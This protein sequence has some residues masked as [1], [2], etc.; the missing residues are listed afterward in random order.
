MKTQISVLVKNEALLSRA[1]SF[2]WFINLF[3]KMDVDM[4]IDSENNVKRLKASKEPYL[5]DVEPGA[6]VILFTDPRAASKQRMRKVTG[7]FIGATIS[8][9]SGGSFLAGGAIGADSVGTS[10]KEDVVECSLN[11]GDTLKLEVKPRS[12]GGVKVKMVQ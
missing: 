12:K 5:I 11:P 9:A 10:I 7:G 2:F 3:K 6:H 8:G 1:Y 4:H